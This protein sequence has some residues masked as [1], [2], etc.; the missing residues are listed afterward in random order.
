V[1]FTAHPR[2]PVQ[3]PQSSIPLQPSEMLLQSLPCAMHVVGMHGIP[4]VDPALVVAAPP[5]PDAVVEEVE[6]PPDPEVAAPPDPDVADDVL[7]ADGAA[8]LDDPGPADT[9]VAAP[10]GPPELVASPTKCGDVEQAPIV[11]ASPSIAL[12][13]AAKLGNAF[14][15]P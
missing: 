11:D 6:A 14:I 13:T 10:P 4:P 5:E 8:P 9:V 12:A 1:P 15:T 7:V 3:L 2:L